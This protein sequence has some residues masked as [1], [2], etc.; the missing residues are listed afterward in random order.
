MYVQKFPVIFNIE[1]ECA[2]KNFS[3]ETFAQM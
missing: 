3:L 1:I 2:V